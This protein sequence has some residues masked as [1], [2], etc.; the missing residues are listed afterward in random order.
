MRGGYIAVQVS[1]LLAGDAFP[2]LSLAALGGWVRLRASNELTGEPVG[3]RAAERIGLTPEVLAELTAVGLV[4]DSGARYRAIGMPEPKRYPSNERPAIRDRVARFRARK[5]D[6][7]PDPSP[8]GQINSGQIKGNEVT[9]GNDVTEDDRAYEAFQRGPIVCAKCRGVI[10]G[11]VLR[12]GA[13]PYHAG[14]C[15]VEVAS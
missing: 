14:G 1:A 11:G 9:S 12:T 13:G 2:D 15:P 6:P 3:E 10:L 4:E 7:S 8:S 5:Q